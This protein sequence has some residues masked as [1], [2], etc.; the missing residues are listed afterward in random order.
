[1]PVP[2]AVPPSGICPTRPRRVADAGAA[3]ADLS[4]VAGELLA[5]G[6]RDRVHQVGAART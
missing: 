1:M 3:E 6:H 5:E 2:A 4:G